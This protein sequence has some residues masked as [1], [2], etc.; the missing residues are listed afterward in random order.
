MTAFKTE[1]PAHDHDVILVRPTRDAITASVVASSDRIGQV[2]FWRDGDAARRTTPQQPMKAGTPVSFTMDGLAPDASYRYRFLWRAS[3]GG[4]PSHGEESSFHTP[5]PTGESFTFTV[6]ADSHLDQGVDPR[7]YEQTL[8]NM[9]AAKPDLFVD[10]GD[11]FMTDKR[12]RDFQRTLPQYDAQRWYFSRLCHSAPLFMVLGNHDGEK[13]DSGTADDDIGPWSYRERTMR[14]PEPVIDGSMYTGKTGFDD[15]RGA[16]YYAFTWGDAQFIMLDPFW[17]TSRRV[18]KGGGGSARGQQGGGQGG[19]GGRGQGGGQGGGQGERPERPS[20]EP[21]KPTDA[22]WNA[23]LGREQYDWL[24]RTLE[25]SKARYRFVFI[26]HL[27]G[28]MGGSESR[29]GVESSPYFEWGGL[30]ADGSPGFK[31]HRAGWPMPIHDLLAKHGVNAVFHGHDHLYVHSQRDG[32]HYQCVPQPG[33]PAGNTR[34]AAQYGYTS[35]TLH[36]SPGHVRINVAPDS[37][38]VE[39][40]RTAVAGGEQG[41]GQG[42][43]GRRGGGGAKEPNGTIIDRYELSPR[44]V[45]PSKKESK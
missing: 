34:S 38:S 19:E 28:G 20:D 29:G 31:E 42:G 45:A 40:V 4:E 43:G 2:E 26:H 21:L 24:T 5:R 27:V 1:V 12:G 13:G 3:A 10:L 6:Q 11:T 8:A 9:L 14:F 35:G 22:S 18:G 15:G 23:T 7:V 32:V 44:A 17:S 16:N 25:S 41:G 30:N 37:A 33:N 39:F 36:G